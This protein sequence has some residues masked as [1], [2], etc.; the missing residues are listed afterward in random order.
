MLLKPTAIINL[1]HRAFFLRSAAKSKTAIAASEDGFVSI[2]DTQRSVHT[3]RLAQKIRAVLLHPFDPLLA[4]VDDSEGVLVVQSFAGELVSTIVPPRTRLT[5]PLYIPQGF[6]DCFFDDSGK[7]LWLAAHRSDEEVELSLFDARVLHGVRNW[8]LMKKSVVS[9]PFGESSCSFH[10]TN[11]PRRIAL[12]M[13]AGQNGQQVLWLN[14]QPDG[15]T[16]D[17]EVE[18]TIIPPVSVPTAQLLVIDYLASASTNS[19]SAK[20]WPMF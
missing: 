8:T 15:F 3:A 6:N 9:D 2:I 13:A 16:S 7:H 4:W 20:A 19:Q 14:S 12:W 5:T 17:R 11:L 10:G 1:E 18:L